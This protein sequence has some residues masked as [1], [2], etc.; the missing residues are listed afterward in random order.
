MRLLSALI[1]AAFLAMPIQQANAQAEPQGSVNFSA[2]DRLAVI[3]LI[4]SY[5]PYYDENRMD[6]H[7]KLFWEDVEAFGFSPEKIV[8]SEFFEVARI[9]RAKQKEKGIQPRHVLTPSIEI[10]TATKI[11][12]IAYLEKYWVKDGKVR[13]DEMGYYSFVA[14]KRGDEWRFSRWEFNEDFKHE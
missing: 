8:G 13:L 6:L 4:S 10:Q 9:L 1:T 7:Q 14:T 2:E 5:G 12:G 11:T 3:N